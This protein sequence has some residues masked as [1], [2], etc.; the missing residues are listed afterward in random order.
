MKAVVKPLVLFGAAALTSVSSWWLL[1]PGD[2]DG[3]TASLLTAPA[4]GLGL[5][6]YD[7]KDLDLVE[8][9]LYEVD[10]SYVDPARVDLDVM[11]MAGLSAIE[12]RVPTALFRRVDGSAL[13]HV[14][15]GE[16]RT[17]VEV[18]EL[19]DVGDLIDALRQVVLIVAEH[20]DPDDVRVDDDADPLASIEYALVNGMLATL[21]P[22]SRLLPPEDSR[23]MD[24][25]NSG[26]FGGL[27]ITIVDRR[28][29]LTVDYPL[30]DTP[31]SK[32][33]LLPDDRILRID[34]ES[35]IN[36]GLD[37]AVDRLRGRVGSTVV[38]TIERDSEPAPIKVSVTRD[39]IKLNPVEGEL[40]SGGIGIVSI[41]SFHANVAA[42]L[43]TTL[44]RLAREAP[45]GELRG[46]VLDLRG[47]PGGY[48]KQAVRVVDKFLEDGD[49]VR[50]K[51][52][53][54][55]DDEEKA[56]PAR[57]EPRYP[58][59]VL[60]NA[61]SASAS[62]IVGGALRN[63][64]RAVI[65]GERS[66]G[67]GSVQNLE[68]LHDGSKLKLT[69]AQYYTGPADRSIQSI[70]IPADLELVP[71]LVTSDAS[72]SVETALYHWR[73]RVRRESDFDNHLE[74]SADDDTVTRWSVRYLKPSDLRRRDSTLK[75][76]REDPEVRFARDVLIASGRR[77]RTADILAGAGGVVES[78]RRKGDIAIA[79]AFEKI[80][81]D[82][83]I[84]PALEGAQ[85]DVKLDL[86]DDGRLI[87]GDEE[88]VWLSVTNKGSEPIYR[89]SAVSESSAELLDGREF[90]FGRLD[91]GET[92]RWSQ[93]VSLNE[94]YPT[95]RTPV[96][97]TFRDAGNP[98][99][100][101]WKTYLPVAGRALP[102]LAARIEV[103]DE[104]GG[105]GDGIAEQGEEITL[106]LTLTNEGDGPSS[107]AFARL[108]N[109]SRRA[110][111]L[112]N[113]SLE[114]GYLRN[115]DGEPCSMPTDDDDT[116][117]DPEAAPAD[118][119]CLRM[120]APGE[121]WTGSLSIR[122]QDEAEEWTV[123]LSFGDAS[124]YDHAAVM[125]SG[126]YETFSNKVDI[127]IPSGEP[128]PD[129]WVRNP[130]QI[131]LSRE[132]PTTTDDEGVVFSG[133]VEDDV[134]LAHIT[135]WHGD[136]KLAL[137]D[138][139]DLKA[140]PFSAEVK[141]EPGLNT[142]TVI[143]TDV[144]GLTTT[145]SVVV[146]YEPKEVTAKVETLDPKD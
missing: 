79:G 90:F 126:F 86:G 57:T 108:R 106:K 146:L 94:G 43:E 109:R 3:R 21:D 52:R 32:A 137:A 74:R 101:T 35:T 45:D 118:P 119:T 82:W 12:R 50:T 121:S 125:R 96:S 55:V 63:N 16:H 105:D 102:R 5:G 142:M 140:I 127:T 129:A 132:H 24:E 93:D 141:L 75:H 27:G 80:G 136:D 30:P 25:E 23:D 144:A 20:V 104:G 143:A 113:A 44:S 95:E 76:L 17:V 42:D 73:E 134:G 135:V 122:L 84:G 29:Q 114:P 139:G 98:D 78:M 60:V 83:S 53:G 131:A 37:G 13:V 10:R 72:G 91:P 123:A 89:L 48:L 88:K 64:D 9:T 58:I 107:E 100:A 115:E 14:Q 6:G 128:M 110:V 62:E 68:G 49:I 138:G 38:L 31:A 47:N 70:G 71:A 46:L 2:P 120:L 28:G 145:R 51:A 112:V 133:M 111:D 65:I 34:G 36:M 81:V 130:P 103:S 117:D 19:K 39:R 69:V 8:A 99:L 124:A 15:V 116:S 67:K 1:G 26:E 4:R 22:H 56:R 11:Y 7:L 59:A 61:S 66:F 85:L 77:S 41:K 87:A 54:K 92:L 97:V 40:L 18:A 33:G